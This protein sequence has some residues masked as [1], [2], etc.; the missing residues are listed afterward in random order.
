MV[1]NKEE[2][3]LDSPAR[4]AKFKASSQESVVK[5]KTY[6]GGE[7]IECISTLLNSTRTAL[8]SISANEDVVGSFEFIG[9]DVKLKKSSLS[10]ESSRSASS[11]ANDAKKPNVS[12]VE[13]VVIKEYPSFDFLLSESDYNDMQSQNFLLNYSEYEKTLTRKL[14]QEKNAEE[15]NSPPISINQETLIADLKAT[16]KV[17]KMIGKYKEMIESRALLN[18]GKD[19]GKIRP[20]VENM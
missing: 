13:T 9:A 2:I 19:H 20:F 7:V 1:V 11:F 6:Y 3:Q 17:N 5:S 18:L 8:S 4:I 15:P 16:N 10:K 12:F 14:D